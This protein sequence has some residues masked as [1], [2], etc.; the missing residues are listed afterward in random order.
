[1]IAM[2]IIM[3]LTNKE[4]CRFIAN[5]VVQEPLSLKL[6][7]CVLLTVVTCVWVWVCVLPPSLVAKEESRLLTGWN[8]SLYLRLYL[9]SEFTFLEAS[10]TS[11][12]ML[13][14]WYLL[15]RESQDSS[16]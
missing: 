7:M 6:P 15:Q 1:M 16:R 11:R 14:R 9:A 3:I 4:W 5:N 8:L 13:T 2:M 10:R 12:N